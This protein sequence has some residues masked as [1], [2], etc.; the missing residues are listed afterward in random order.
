MMDQFQLIIEKLFY[1]TPQ[2]I[3]KILR[4]ISVDK[5][6]QLY[7][8][9]REIITTLRKSLKENIESAYITEGEGESV[10]YKP[11]YK[12]VK[13]VYEI[14]KNNP[15]DVSKVFEE[16]KICINPSEGSYELFLNL[17]ILFAGLCDRKNAITSLK[18]NNNDPFINTSLKYKEEECLIPLV[19]LTLLDRN[20]N[21]LKEFFIKFYEKLETYIKFFPVYNGSLFLLTEIIKRHSNWEDDFSKYFGKAM[22]LDKFNINFKK[23]FSKTVFSPQIIM[24]AVQYEPENDSST[25]LV[26]LPI[27]KYSDLLVSLIESNYLK[28]EDVL[29]VALH[30]LLVVHRQGIVKLWIDLYDKLKITKEDLFKNKE[31]YLDLINAPSSLS[32]QIGLDSVKTIVKNGQFQDKEEIL[33]SLLSYNLNNP[34]QKVVKESLS[35][36]RLIAEKNPTLNGLVLEELVSNIITPHKA[37]RVDIIKWISKNINEEIPEHLKEILKEIYELEEVS[38]VEKELLKD[39]FFTKNISIP[40]MIDDEFMETLEKPS[41]KELVELAKD[42]TEDSIYQ[43]KINQLTKLLEKYNQTKKLEEDKPILF[44]FSSYVYDEKISITENIDDFISFVVSRMGEYTNIDFELFLSGFVKFKNYKHKYRFTEHFAPLLKKLEECNL[45]SEDKLWIVF[46]YYSDILLGMLIYSWLN[47]GKIFEFSKDSNAINCNWSVYVDEILYNKFLFALKL[48]Q[49]TDEDYRL[50]STP[51]YKT[52]W[53]A[54]EAFTYRFIKYPKELINIDDLI[55]ALFRFPNNEQTRSRVWSIINYKIKNIEDPIEAA[56]AIAFAPIEIMKKAVDYFYK[57]FEEKQATDVILLDAYYY[58]AKRKEPLSEE[59]IRFRLFNSALRSRYGINNPLDELPI[60]KEFKLNKLRFSTKMIDSPAENIAFENI[61]LE[62]INQNIDKLIQSKNLNKTERASDVS[63]LLLYSRPISKNFTETE[64]S[65]FLMK[66]NDKDVSYYP[67]FIPYIFASY[68]NLLSVTFVYLY[69][70]KYPAMYQRLFEAGILK[71]ESSY[72]IDFAINL[73][74]LGT[75]PYIDV[76][77]YL[78]TIFKLFLNKNYI[79]ME[80]AIDVITRAFKDGRITVFDLVESL[81][82]MF[83]D[84]S[85]GFKY[86]RE[87]IDFLCEYETFY[88]KIVILAIE[89]FLGNIDESESTSKTLSQILDIYYELLL[90]NKRIIED[91]KAFDF[92]TKL[93]KTKNKTTIKTRASLLV[94]LEKPTNGYYLIVDILSDLLFDLIQ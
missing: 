24:T 39:L 17:Q 20:E 15:S 3:K 48:L 33:I 22:Y 42:F 13:D 43:K 72:D 60:L 80:I 7:K 12:N 74:E 30:K 5:R 71:I 8:Q 56:I 36:I 14:I 1:G 88:E 40:K 82:K 61:A 21:W 6:K 28:R 69:S 92:I 19:G 27:A 65:L 70:F 11:K 55:L 2:D 51:S 23:N 25:D 73:I 26:N 78:D 91:K 46:Y 67:Q 77:P 93:S 49:Q 79:Y 18:Y 38:L 54:P 35:I 37:V 89:E 75:L 83:K 57:Y 53:I 45:V 63:D 90:K 34:I 10:K 86:F 31:I 44:D 47:D 16:N 32:M 58:E 64:L 87:S 66:F 4:D 41:L 81:K 68:Y 9:T 85:K 29:K 84:T 76:R 62:D 50:L 52:G 59:N 94:K